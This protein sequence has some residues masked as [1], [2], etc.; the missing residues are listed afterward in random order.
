M[1]YNISRILTS[2][3]QLN[4]TAYENYSPVYIS[5]TNVMVFAGHFA[6][7]PAVLIYA[8]LYHGT[9]IAAAFKGIFTKAHVEKKDIHMTLMEAYDEVPGWWYFLILLTGAVMAF[10][11]IGLFPT[12][13]PVWGVFFA[14]SIGLV[15]I[16]PIGLIEA[17]SNVEVTINVLAEMVAG[18]AI[19]RNPVA[20]MIFS[21]LPNV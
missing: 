10:T 1:R 13:M 17:V 11:M 21:K 16:I 4:I 6:L 18:F 5:A 15:F 20:L 14:I 7:Y 9:E 3:S 8:Y 2:S 19:P 12:G